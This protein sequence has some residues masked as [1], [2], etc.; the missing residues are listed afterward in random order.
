MPDRPCR[1]TSLV[2]VVRAR[3]GETALERFG[4][5]ED[6]DVARP[7]AVSDLLILT[8]PTG[9]RK[10]KFEVDFGI[11]GG[12]SRSLDIAVGRNC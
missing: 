1:V 6:G 11:G 2:A 4:K 12:A 3:D 8:V 5:R 10:P 9:G 7:T